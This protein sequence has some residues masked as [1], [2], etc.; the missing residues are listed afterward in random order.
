MPLY[1]NCLDQEPSTCGISCCDVSAIRVLVLCEEFDMTD[2]I[3]TASY[4]RN[5]QA[6]SEAQRQH[7]ILTSIGEH[8]EIGVEEAAQVWELLETP[9]TVDTICRS[10]GANGGLGTERITTLLAEMYDQ[11]LI[12]LSPDS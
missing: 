2:I 3:P 5:P 4:V 8:A 12:Q 9:Q 6:M 11:D 7:A 10:I 1:A